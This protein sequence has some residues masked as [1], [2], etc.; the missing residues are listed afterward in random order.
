[1]LRDDRL[2]CASILRGAGHIDAA[3]HNDAAEMPRGFTSNTNE[4]REASGV[5]L[6]ATTAALNRAAHFRVL[7]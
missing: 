7:R 5:K 1:V 2:T 3:G 4:A 6:M